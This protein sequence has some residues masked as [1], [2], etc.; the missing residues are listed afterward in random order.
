L[1][2][3]ATREEAIRFI[4]IRDRLINN[5]RYFIGL[6]HKTKRM[7]NDG[8]SEVGFG[9]QIVKHAKNY[10]RNYDKN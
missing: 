9:G 2:V 7:E 3:F 5:N 1:L 10:E 4:R 6:G 8:W